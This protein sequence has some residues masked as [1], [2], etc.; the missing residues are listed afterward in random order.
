MKSLKFMFGLIPLLDA[1]LGYLFFT[2]GYV[3]LGTF[4]IVLSMLFGVLFF[5]II[6]NQK[7]IK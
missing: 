2:Q 1:I 5:G 7:N 6:M 4:L 3:W